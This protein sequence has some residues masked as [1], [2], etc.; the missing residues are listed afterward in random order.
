MT[1]SPIIIIK[2]VYYD[3]RLSTLRG[4]LWTGDIK[5]YDWGVGRGIGIGGI[6]GIDLGGFG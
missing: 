4:A 2:K 3:L 1:K 6:F 5:Y